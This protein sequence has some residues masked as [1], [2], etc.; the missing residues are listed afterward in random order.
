MR[1]TA[2]EHTAGL[3][4]FASQHTWPTLLP[5]R[6]LG[7]VY[8]IFN[9][10]YVMS[11]QV[12]YFDRKQLYDTYKSRMMEAGFEKLPENLTPGAKPQ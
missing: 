1:T 6:L 5:A 3:T 11:E 10:H 7:L 2:A 9:V 8:G 12:K 4:L